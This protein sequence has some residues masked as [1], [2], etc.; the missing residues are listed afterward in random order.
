MTSRVCAP[1]GLRC[2]AWLPH[3]VRR[4]LANGANSFVHRGWPAGGC[5]A[6]HGPAGGRRRQTSR[7]GSRR[8]RCFRTDD[9][10]TEEPQWPM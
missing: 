7:Y 9:G 10:D 2:R 6:G 3:L 4:L 5:G 8:G 1:V